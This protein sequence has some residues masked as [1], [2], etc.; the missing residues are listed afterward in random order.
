MCPPGDFVSE[1]SVTL[2]LLWVFQHLQPRF[3]LLQQM[4]VGLCVDSVSHLS[5][6][7]EDRSCAWSSR[8]KWMSWKTAGILASRS[9]C[10]LS[11]WSPCNSA[12]RLLK[13]TAQ[14]CAAL[15]ESG[16]SDAE[17]V[18]KEHHLHPHFWMCPVS[19]PIFPRTRCPVSFGVGWKPL[20]LPPAHSRINGIQGNTG[21]SLSPW[22]C[23][24]AF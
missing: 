23:F 6:S 17:A 19:F 16:L 1:D 12:L 21:A 2:V 9:W 8:P 13:G 7:R 4:E 5:G 11:V 22:T 3:Q 10:F 20:Q 14:E 18:A 24:A 15:S